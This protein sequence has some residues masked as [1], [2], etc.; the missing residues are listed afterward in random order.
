M[1]DLK[2][3]C[4]FSAWEDRVSRKMQSKMKEGINQ[5]ADLES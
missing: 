1:K 2:R 4:L 3:K 5:K